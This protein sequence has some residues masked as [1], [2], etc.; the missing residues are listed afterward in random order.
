MLCDKEPPEIVVAFSCLS[1]RTRR[2]ARL[3]MSDQRAFVV[4][5]LQGLRGIGIAPKRLWAQEPFSIAMSA[6]ESGVVVELLDYL[7]RYLDYFR[8]VIDV[9]IGRMG[10]Y[11]EARSLIFAISLNRIFAE[12]HR[13][14]DVTS[15]MKSGPGPPM[16]L[17][18]AA[19]AE[20]RADRLVSK[21]AG[22]EVEP[23]PAERAARYGAET[24]VLDWRERLMWSRCGRSIWW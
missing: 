7:S 11:F 24:P 4:F 1:M 20:L 19:T 14:G 12:A 8:K 16:T 10:S 15:N 2:C 18:N 5:V 22:R 23:D 6:P 3:E 9:Y 21:V 13:A 17:G